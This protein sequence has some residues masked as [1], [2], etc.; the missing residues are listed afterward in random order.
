MHC[1]IEVHAL[2]GMAMVLNEAPEIEIKPPPGFPVCKNF[3][4]DHSRDLSFVRPLGKGIKGNIF[5]T[6]PVVKLVLLYLCINK[7]HRKIPNIIPHRKPFFWGGLIFEGAY[8]VLSSAY[9]ET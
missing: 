2:D 6:C 7:A 9:Q 1:H 4:N 5:I 8:I 3:Y